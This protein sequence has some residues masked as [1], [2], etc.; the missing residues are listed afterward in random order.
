MT[1]DDPNLT[2]KSD[3]AASAASSSRPSGS[4]TQGHNSS[5]DLDDS[6]SA[7]WGSTLEFVGRSSAVDISL[8]GRSITEA[9]MSHTGKNVGTP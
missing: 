9:D 1:L 7:L 5:S 2:E 6:K 3:Q 4:C 8:S